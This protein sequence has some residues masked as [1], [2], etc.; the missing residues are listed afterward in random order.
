MCARCGAITLFGDLKGL[1]KIKLD[2]E[3]AEISG[4]S[5]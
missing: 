4:E 1:R 3:N 2:N 5:E